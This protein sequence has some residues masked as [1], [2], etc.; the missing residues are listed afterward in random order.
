MKNEPL[1][2]KLRPNKISDIIGQKH[3]FEKDKVLYKRSGADL[4]LPGRR[5]D[6]IPRGGS[7]QGAQ[8]RDR[9][10]NILTEC[11]DGAVLRG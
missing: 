9:G 3:L 7:A 4:H 1:A 2:N 5:G 8:G 6:E 11:T 10:Q